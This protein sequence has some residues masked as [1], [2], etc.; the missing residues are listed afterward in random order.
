M[1][2][3]RRDPLAAWPPLLLALA[4]AMAG[5]GWGD[6]A[7]GQARQYRIDPQR[8]AVRVLVYR[9]GVLSVL[10]HDHVMVAQD[11]QGRLSLDGADVA[12]S[13]LT[14]RVNAAAFAVD[15][16]AERQKAG[17]LSELTEGNRQSIRDVMNGPEVLDVARFPAISAASERVSGRLP[18]LAVDMRVNIRGREQLVRVPA[19]VAVALDHVRATGSVELLQ[20]A[21]GIV[22]YETL[23]GSIA[24]QDKIVVQFDILAVP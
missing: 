24:V 5:L 22:P 8:S 7:W 9:K 21:F 3:H 4:L 2:H 17:F 14:L 12:R 19:R 15:A 18:D 20:T 13:S 23:M 10:A 6:A 1:M 16:P 11:V